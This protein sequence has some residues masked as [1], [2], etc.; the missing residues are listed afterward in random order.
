VQRRLTALASRL[1]WCGLAAAALWGLP[2]L[3]YRRNPVEILR[4][5]VALGVAAIPEGLPVTATAAL[6]R[7]MARMRERGIVVRRLATAE[8][9][10][11]VTVVCTDKTGTLTE[12]DM[13]LEA[14]W[15]GRQRTLAGGGT[16]ALRPRP[17]RV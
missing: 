9:L 6:V 15:L 11:G 10:G 13:R 4:D 12:N 16:G 8:T 1:A 14:V 7:A 3:A 5:T 17:A 2:T